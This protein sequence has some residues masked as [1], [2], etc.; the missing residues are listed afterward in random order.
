[1]VSTS[2]LVWFTRVATTYGHP[3]GRGESTYG[4]AVTKRP[5]IVSL[6][7]PYVKVNTNVWGG[8]PERGHIIYIERLNRRVT[9]LCSGGGGG[10]RSEAAA[11]LPAAT[12]STA[13]L[14]GRAFLP[15]VVLLLAALAPAGPRPRGAGQPR[16]GDH[17]PT[18]RARITHRSPDLDAHG[19]Q[20][21]G[22]ATTRTALV[23]D[24]AVF[25]T[26]ATVRQGPHPHPGAWGL[27]ALS[28]ELHASL[29][30]EYPSP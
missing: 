26:A 6:A 22:G 21:P 23:A 29:P 5:A 24:R 17:L 7:K 20:H 4:E 18:D 28:S 12:S 27:Q 30:R 16:Q 3:S 25:T 10:G 11:G 15:E 13:E 14:G 1:M 9:S 8:A 2:L 19:H